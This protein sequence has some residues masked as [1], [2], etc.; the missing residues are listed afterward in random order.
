M[1][2]TKPLMVYLELL[3]VTSHLEE[4]PTPELYAR[5]RYLVAEFA[6]LQ[7]QYDEEQYEEVESNG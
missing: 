1:N 2:T 7:N 5:F 4:N 6:R 3:Q